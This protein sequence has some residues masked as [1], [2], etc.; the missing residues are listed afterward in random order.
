[1]SEI[2]YVDVGCESDEVEKNFA[3]MTNIFLRRF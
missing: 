2:C 1:M 3:K